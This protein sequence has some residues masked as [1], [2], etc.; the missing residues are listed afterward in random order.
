MLRSRKR[1]KQGVG[2][3]PLLGAQ[4]ERR[5]ERELEAAEPAVASTSLDAS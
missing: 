2:L 3:A 1:L 4:A 5:A